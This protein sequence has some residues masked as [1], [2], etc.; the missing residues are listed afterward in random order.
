MGILHHNCLDAI[1]TAENQGRLLEREACLRIIS[2]FEQSMRDP[3]IEGQPVLTA[4]RV[5]KE[6]IKA[7]GVPHETGDR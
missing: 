7:R 5:L 1:R 2:R 3:S 4:C 6:A